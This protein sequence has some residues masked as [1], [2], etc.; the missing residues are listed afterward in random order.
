MLCRW[1]IG[2]SALKEPASPPAAPLRC[3][4]PRSVLGREGEISILSLC[5]SCAARR[6]RCEVF[7]GS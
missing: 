4:V 1:Q 5:L 6:P 2:H 3:I 7:L